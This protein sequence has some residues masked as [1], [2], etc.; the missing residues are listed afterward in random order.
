MRTLTKNNEIG[1]R[2]ALNLGTSDVYETDEYGNIKTMFVGGEEVPIVT[3]EKV[4]NYSEVHE[5]DAPFS[6]SGGEAEATEFGVSLSDYTATIT[7]LRE[8]LPLT[9][10]SLI[11]KESEVGYMDE[12]HTKVN[13][14]T[15][16]YTVIKISES[17][18][19]T[20]ALLRKI[21]K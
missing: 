14:K 9:E 21:V 7:F 11:W 6:M 16:D 5:F 15:A 17:L 13:P 1:L 4:T 18:N 12:E 2:Y 20:R 10:T 3:G 8:T 19:Y